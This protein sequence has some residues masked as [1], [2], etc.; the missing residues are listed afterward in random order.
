MFLGSVPK[1]V[2]SFRILKLLFGVEMATRVT[3]MLTESP[4]RPWLDAGNSSVIRVVTNKI[5]R[6]L[7][8]DNQLFEKCIT[9]AHGRLGL[10]NRQRYGMRSDLTEMKIGRQLALV[11]S[12][13]G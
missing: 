9:V 4:A 11:T 2:V 12:S 10:Q 1:D 8:P 5:H 3:R 6:E 13:S 7:T